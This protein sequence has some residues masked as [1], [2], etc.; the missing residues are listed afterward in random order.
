MVRDQSSIVYG[1][2]VFTGSTQREANQAFIAFMRS[3]GAR[4]ELRH[5]GLDPV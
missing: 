2:T 1:A 4:K 5:A 3:D